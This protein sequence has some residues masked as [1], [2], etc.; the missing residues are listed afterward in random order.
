MK[1]ITLLFFAM[2]MIS[3]SITAKKAPIVGKWLL[4]QVDAG[5]N[6]QDV[7]QEIEFKNDGYV[8]MMG[9]VVGE[10]SLNKKTKTFTIESEMVKEFAGVRK[11]TKH[12][13]TE[14]VIVGENDK[15]FF[16]ALNP[17]VIEKEN[18]K[19]GFA[20][21]WTTSGEE[22]GTMYITF[23]LPDT[24]SSVT[25]TEYSTSKSSGTWMYNSKEKSMI[26]LS[27]DRMFRGKNTVISVKNKELVLENKGNKI[28]LTK[29]KEKEVKKAVDIERLSF[30][31]EE[32]YTEDG[33][34]KYEADVEKLPWKDPMK[35]Y[36][37][38]KLKKSLEYTM[39]TLVE[40]TK[41][42]E[43]KELS[44][45]LVTDY[46]YEV[47]TLD[48]IFLGFDR[49]SLPEDAEIPTLSLESNDPTYTYVPFPYEVYTFRV[50]SQ[51]QSIIV[52]GGEFACT[53]VEL[54]GDREEKI[55]LWMINDKPGIVAKVIEEKEGH[56]GDLEYK[57]FELIKIEN[58]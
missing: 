22:G 20:G 52:P 1:K 50:I 7:Y 42:F 10:W 43:V 12:S 36:E 58:N 34:P 4:T 47:V 54:I 11:I 46:N 9:R 13:K 51:N 15:M 35:M 18:K 31:Q 38:L 19:S 16:T 26:I 39:S 3:A 45:K 44:A 53:I 29:Q 2:L 55:K 21:T 37:S 30:T 56:F 40:D 23:Q 5:G 48:N 8:S 6:M 24:Y 28:I 41:A 27:M 57:M 25:K 17:K 33:E 49:N 14:L 32:F